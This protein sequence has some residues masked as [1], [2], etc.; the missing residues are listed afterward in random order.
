MA[1]GGAAAGVRV[2]NAISRVDSAI[3]GI[4]AAIG[5]ITSAFQN[6]DVQAAMKEF[7]SVV[8]EAAG[9]LWDGKQSISGGG[10][11]GGGGGFSGSNNNSAADAARALAEEFERLRQSLIDFRDELI[12]G[13]FAKLSPEEAYRVAQEAYAEV[14]AKAAAG[15]KEAIAELEGVSR[16]YLKASEAYYASTEAYFKDR[17]RVLAAVEEAIRYTSQKAGKEI[18]AFADGGLFSG[19]LRL[20]GER[21]PE[22]EVTGPARYYSAEQTVR[23]LHGSR[24][25]HSDPLT[26]QL[27]QEVLADLRVLIAQG[28]VI[29]EETVKKLEVLGLRL[30]DLGGEIRRAA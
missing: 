27:L 1:G 19:G 29:G 6:A 13:S 24:T 20:V 12:G 25:G 22:L 28:A 30:D 15:D 10:G 4:G 5:A 23:M 3:A 2:D 16:D 26:Q 18:P 14:E 21:G 17:D 11:G 9:Q 8:G 7:T